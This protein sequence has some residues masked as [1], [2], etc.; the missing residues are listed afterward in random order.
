MGDG[1][2]QFVRAHKEIKAVLCHKE[3]M[4]KFERIGRKIKA[5]VV[6]DGDSENSV[7]ARQDTR[8]MALII[9]AD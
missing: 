9:F 3:D 6:R 2:V 7:R 8:P 1:S 5:T 4:E